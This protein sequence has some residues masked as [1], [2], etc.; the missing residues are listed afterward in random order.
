MLNR[1]RIAFSRRLLL[2]S[3]V[4]FVASVLASNRTGEDLAALLVSY[5]AMYPG[6][7]NSNVGPVTR[8]PITHGIYL[9]HLP[10]RETP[11]FSLGSNVSDR[12]DD[13]Q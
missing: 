9:T 12:V 1:T 2:V 11:F 3:L 10:F 4:G 13:A 7:L 6:P 8:R 5:L